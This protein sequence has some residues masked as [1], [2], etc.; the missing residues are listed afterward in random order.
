MPS[1]GLG[2]FGSDHVSHST[3][4]DAVNAALTL[5]YRHVDC[6]SV[7]ANEDQ[8]GEVLS[9][10]LG[11]TAPRE[12]F[13]I[14]SKVWN[15]G[16][17]DVASACETTLSDLRLETL[18][19]YLVHWPFPNFH[20]PHCDVDDRNPFA[21]PYQHEVF[22][23]TWAQMERLVSRGLVRHIGTSNMT[24]A[25]L[26]LLLPEVSITPAVNQMELHPHFQ[27]PELFDYL[28]ANAIAPI[29]FC[30]IG[31]PDR[32]ERDRT[33]EDTS[34]TFDPVVVEIA[35]RHG[36]H[37]ATACVKW[38]IERGHTPIPFSTNA[39]NIRANLEATTTPRFTS[40]E[41]ASI[42]SIDKRCRLIKG[43]VFLWEDDQPWQDLW[44]EDGVIAR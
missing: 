26:D 1:I 28:L 4:A 9:N 14:S 27:Q 31:S 11:N 37:P 18:D 38:A 41:M 44:D 10:H 15:D 40:A 39:S 6:A 19:M 17:D 23:E 25:K 2:T 13:W 3:V 12:D 43:Q 34:P 21:V 16:H 35:E 20:P 30:P 7:Y 8:I 32:P 29:G 24:E 42:T 22:L 5:G 33:P 36:I